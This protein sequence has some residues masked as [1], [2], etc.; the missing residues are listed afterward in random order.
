M[1]E[2]PA[3]P[4]MVRA[5]VLAHFFEV[6]QDLGWNPIPVMR[7][8]GLTRA[9]VDKQDH[10]IPSDTAVALLE[11]AAASTGCETFGLRMAESRHL[12]HLGVVSLLITHQPTLR[13]ALV[14]TMQY[15]H[16]LNSSL[17]M[18]IEDDGEWV[19]IREEVVMD[20][21]SRQVNE[22]A[23]GVL[24]RL[25]AAVLGTRWK[26]YSV[27]FTH[28]APKDMAIHRRLFP[29]TL[30]F[31]SD[32]NGIV[33]RASNLDAPNPAA[34]PG[35]ARCVR[36]LL[37][38]MPA[39]SDP[40]MVMEV[41]KAIYLMLPAGRANSACVA[42]GMGLSVRSLQR[43]LDGAGTSFSALLHQVRT[44]LASYYVENPA[45]DLGRM[46]GLLGYGSHASFTRWFTGQ[47][48][49]APSRWR[50][51]GGRLTETA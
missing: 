21:P 9:S 46:A 7:E 14:T 18:Q 36:Q 51:R 48:G 10:R 8:A 16:L 44:E 42:E 23:L 15:R 17:A 47:F 38:T 37:E 35:M 33:C 2:S 5:A 29:C 41:R 6:A 25:C 11:T 12:S 19:L 50:T 22:L 4:T 40:S 31:D 34:D 45:L 28:S 24:F 49:M 27:N 26:P 39:L 30:E 43:A 20:R 13:D 32:F 3:M 1:P